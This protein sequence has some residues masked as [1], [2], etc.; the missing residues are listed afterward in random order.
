MSGKVYF[1]LPEDGDVMAQVVEAVP[2][3]WSWVDGFL[4]AESGLIAA[5]RVLK[6]TGLRLSR[7]HSIKPTI[8]GRRR[9]QEEGES[10]PD[11]FGFVIEH[12]LPGFVSFDEAG[13][14]EG[15]VVTLALAKRLAAGFIRLG[16]RGGLWFSAGC[17]DNQKYSNPAICDIRLQPWEGFHCSE[18]RG[19]QPSR[20][21]L[22]WNAEFGGSQAMVDP[23]AEACRRLGLKEYDPVQP[24]AVAG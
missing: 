11:I 17:C 14:Q 5:S 21:K 8:V 9:S 4:S 22:E 1:E 19:E 7:F 2:D 20:V 23:I 13:F 18:E 16:Y 10:V 3:S 6:D 24:M 15:K 12:K